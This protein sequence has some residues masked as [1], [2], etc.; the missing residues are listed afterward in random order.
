[1]ELGRGFDLWA[2]GKMRGSAESRIIA[3]TH[4]PILGLPLNEVMRS[5]I[6]LPLQQV[7]KVYPWAISSAPAQS[8]ESKSIEQCFEAPSR[9]VTRPPP[10]RR[11]WASAFPGRPVVAWWRD[12]KTLDG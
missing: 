3:M 8:P 6:A 2:L 11:G 10:V 9:P 4:N 7:L 5:D 12:E 1:M